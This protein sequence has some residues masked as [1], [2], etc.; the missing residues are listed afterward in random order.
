MPDATHGGMDD[1]ICDGISSVKERRFSNRRRRKDED[2]G[3]KP[4][5]LEAYLLIIAL[6]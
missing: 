5:L 6:E 1:D 4:P 3:F 2:G